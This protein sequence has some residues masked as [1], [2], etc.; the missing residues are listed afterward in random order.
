[1]TSLL[2]IFVL[3]LFLGELH[4]LSLNY[5]V[6][7]ILGSKLPISSHLILFPF[8]FRY[9]FIKLDNFCKLNVIYNY[10]KLSSTNKFRQLTKLT[11][12]ANTTTV[13]TIFS[14]V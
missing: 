6:D 12:F 1:M 13:H 14:Y 9:I 2:V 4:F 11:T 3:P 5:G 7:V 10:G 8:F